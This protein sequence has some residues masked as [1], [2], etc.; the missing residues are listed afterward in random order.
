MIKKDLVERSSVRNF[1]KALDGGLRAG[2][3]GVITSRKGSGKTSLLVQL[4]L[5]QL[6]QDKFVV[7][8]SFSQ[9]VDYAMTWYKDMFK[10]LAEKKHLDKKD[11]VRD[12]MVANRIILNFNQETVRTSQ[13]VKTIRALTEGG[14]KPSVL[15]IDDFNFVKALPEAMEQMKSFAKEMGLTIWYTAA[16]DVRSCKIAD[17]L[18]KYVDDIDIIL[19]LEPQN[20]SIKIQALKVHDKTAFDT[21]I[22]LD[23]KTMLITDK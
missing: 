20:D 13:I 4:G 6:L 1:E 9:H 11:E 8:I 12:Q 7:H 3:I 10:D 14:S 15:M 2:E 23:T 16:E 21:G 19:Y 22:K 17:T 5:D 18:A